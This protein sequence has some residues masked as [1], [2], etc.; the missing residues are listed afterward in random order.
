M[1]YPLMHMER[2]ER[3]EKDAGKDL[4]KELADYLRDDPSAAIRNFAA[5]LLE[6]AAEAPIK[7][8][9]RVLYLR[10]DGRPKNKKKEM[11]LAAEVMSDLRKARFD[12]PGVKE[13]Q[14]LGATLKRLRRRAECKRLSLSHLKAVWL[15]H[16][17]RAADGNFIVGADGGDEWENLR[18]LKS[19]LKD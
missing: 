17:G 12:D 16:R 13:T 14:V 5:D 11:E 9:P 10:T 15:R 1:T 8:L 6:R 19:R 4:L 7:D 2:V 18:K 3:G